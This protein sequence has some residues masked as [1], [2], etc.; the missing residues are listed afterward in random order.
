MRVPIVILALVAT[1][2][3]ADVSAAQGKASNSGK[4]SNTKKDECLMPGLRKGHA[5][6]DWILTHLDKACV[7]APDPTP[8]PTP[9]PTPTPTPTP[10]PTPTPTPDPTPTPVPAGPVGSITG[11]VF[12]DDD[13]SYM[14][15]AGEAL[16][17]GWT[18]QLISNVTN[19]VVK[20]ATTTGNGQYLIK[21]IPAGDYRLCVVPMPGF[22]QVPAPQFN[23]DCSSGRGHHTPIN[24]SNTAWEGL[25]FGYN[26]MSAM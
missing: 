10:D 1:P 15:D 19:A 12:A 11:V 2:F 25:N 6:V 24:A 26:D 5:A 8:T 3:I 18:V 22:A 13:W 4:G 23:I 16:L 21:D 17:S 14:P 7:P 9:D 20:S